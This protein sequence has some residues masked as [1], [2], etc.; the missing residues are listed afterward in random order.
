MVSIC[1]IWN[2]A[3]Q[4]DLYVNNNTK[5]DHKLYRD[6]EP[7]IWILLKFWPRKDAKK[8]RNRER[9][10]GPSPL[11]PTWLIIDHAGAHYIWILRPS[12]RSEFKAYKKF[13]K[14]TYSPFKKAKYLFI[15]LVFVICYFLVKYN[16]YFFHHIAPGRLVYNGAE[17]DYVAAFY[18][19]QLA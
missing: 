19:L 8:L 16:C 5:F 10:R 18:R 3:S 2:K 6:H 15:E 17:M 13:V 14:L 9:S 1:N 12:L 11:T 4:R 7:G